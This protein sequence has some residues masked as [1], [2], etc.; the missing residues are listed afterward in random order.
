MK[1]TDLL[2]ILLGLLACGNA[3]ADSACEAG[4]FPTD[5]SPPKK[6]VWASP[7]AIQKLTH[8]DNETPP[9]VTRIKNGVVYFSAA[10]PPGLAYFQ[11][12]YAYDLDRAIFVSVQGENYE[13]VRPKRKFPIHKNQMYR[14]VKNGPQLHRAE[15]ITVLAADAGT[16]RRLACVA[17]RFFVSRNSSD[18]QT[19]LH[20]PPSDGWTA[21]SVIKDGIPVKSNNDDDQ[22]RENQQALRNILSSVFHPDS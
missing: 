19:R 7:K 10:I 11:D 2:A 8:A 13:T 16:V 9:E 21:V 18:V 1:R 4:P 20:L 14:Y 22:V 5:A 6:N 15:R 12:W 3:L 17:N